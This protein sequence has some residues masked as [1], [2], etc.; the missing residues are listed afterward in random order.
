MNSHKL[1]EPRFLLCVIGK[2]H[3]WKKAIDRS[4]VSP[5]PPE[6]GA[7][8]FR[9]VGQ[10]PSNPTLSRSRQT[11]GLPV[12]RQPVRDEKTR[13]T[14]SANGRLAQR[15]RDLRARRPVGADFRF[16]GRTGSGKNV[17]SGNSRYRLNTCTWPSPP[18]LPSITNL[19]PTGN[20][21]GR[22]PEPYA[23]VT[24]CNVV[25]LA[26]QCVGQLIRCVERIFIH[27]I[28][29]GEPCHAPDGPIS[30]SHI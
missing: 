27:V 30:P 10:W 13:R 7:F 22:R 5:S 9:G 24:S 2:R 16:D 20:R 11:F 23:M 1:A 29:N 28:P 26:L 25:T 12:N 4:P 15:A 3:N 19:V 6:A 14:V 8:A 18:R 21:L 17:P